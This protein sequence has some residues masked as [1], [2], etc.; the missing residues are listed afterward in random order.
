MAAPK[1][2]PLRPDAPADAAHGDLSL[3]AL[4]GAESSAQLTELAE[5]LSRDAQL[6][7]LAAKLASSLAGH[8]ADDLMQ[9]TLERVVRD[10]AREA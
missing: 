1:V 5:R 2:V 4:R 6:R 7:A 8:S 3:L 10:Q 9:C